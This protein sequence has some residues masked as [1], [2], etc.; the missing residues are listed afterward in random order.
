VLKWSVAKTLAGKLKLKTTRKVMQKFGKDLTVPYGK[1]TVSMQS[2][3]LAR[4]E[5]QFKRHRTD[6]FV[7]LERL[8]KAAARTIKV[9]ESEC[10]ICG[11]VGP[12]EMHHVKKL[13]KASNSIKANYLSRIM[14]T[15]NRKQIPVCVPCHKLIHT[16]K[17]L[18]FAP[19][20][21]EG[22]KKRL[23]RK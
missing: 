20:C 7:R 16:G 8:L 23:N 6:P 4:P 9:F 3:T 5:Q 2:P 12:L 21:E 19:G 14:S 22:F 18:N 1:G 13:A 17:P 11:R 10:F 15:M